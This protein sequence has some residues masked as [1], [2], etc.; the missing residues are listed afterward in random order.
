MSVASEVVSSA[1]LLTRRARRQLSEAAALL[2]EIAFTALMDPLAPDLALMGRATDALIVLHDLG[3]H[4]ADSL[5]APGRPVRDLV[6]NAVVTLRSIDRGAFAYAGDFT[7]VA[8]LADGLEG[9][10]AG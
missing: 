3:A 10:L 5:K 4:A 7:A 9:F 2:E 6:A 1:G 8:Q